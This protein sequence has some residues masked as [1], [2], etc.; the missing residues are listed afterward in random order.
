MIKAQGDAVP[1]QQR[2]ARESPQLATTMWLVV[3]DR[4]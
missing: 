1:W 3:I 2:T 4:V